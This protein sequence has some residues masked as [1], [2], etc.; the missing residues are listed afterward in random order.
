MIDTT[1]TLPDGHLPMI[2]HHDTKDDDLYRM[3]QA[4]E[5]KRSR[6]ESFIQHIS[7]FYDDAIIRTRKM[8]LFGVCSWA[9]A[10]LHQS[11]QPSTDIHPHLVQHK[12]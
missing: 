5:D 4:Q 12:T 2:L 8:G 10:G 9:D 1:K 11:H 3:K 7:R 6:Q